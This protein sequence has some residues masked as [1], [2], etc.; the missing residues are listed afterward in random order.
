MVQIS[1][2]DPQTISTVPRAATQ[3]LM[4]LPQGGRIDEDSA[5]GPITDVLNLS[6]AAKALME[7]GGAPSLGASDAAPTATSR[8][9]MRAMSA[10]SEQ[11]TQYIDKL[12]AVVREKFGLPENAGWMVSG[13]ALDM[14]DA[15]AK[16]SGLKKPELPAILRDSNAVNTKAEDKERASEIGVF[17][18][19]FTNAGDRKFGDHLEI[20]F[21]RSRQDRHDRQTLV[22]LKDQRIDASA[23]IETV[24]NSPW[25]RVADRQKPENA[26]D[27]A[28]VSSDRGH[29]TTL[30]ALVHSVG[31]D[32]MAHRSAVDMLET[33]KRYLPHRTDPVPSR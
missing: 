28:I 24:K 25:S 7:Q 31:T 4:A 15:L 2:A 9:V 26:H 1:F 10:W 13:A 22:R 33:I 23:L 17:G 27:Y 19:N 6:D 18:V 14:L 12:D 20:V 3:P 21:D 8:D 32:A 11:Q 16:D 30:A 29:K 5:R